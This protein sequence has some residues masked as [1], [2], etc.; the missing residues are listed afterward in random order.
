M[1]ERGLFQGGGRLYAELRARSAVVLTPELVSAGRRRLAI[2]CA[3]ITTWTVGAYLGLLFLAHGP[4]SVTL[5][6]VALGLAV[7]GVAFCIGHDANHDAFLGSR[8]ANR[9]VGL[10]FDFIGVSSYIWRSKHNQA[11]HSFT[12][13]Q[14]ADSDIEQMP[15]ARL[16]PDQPLHW[17]HRFQHIYMW[18]LYGLFT[19]RHHLFGDIKQL[20][21]GRIADLTPVARPRGVELAYFIGGKVV[22]WSWTAVIPLL[23]HPWY[24]VLGAFLIVSWVS[25]FTVATVFQLAH[26]TDDAH[27]SSIDE[28]RAGP[29]KAWADHQVETTVDF[30][31]S[32]AFLRWY[33]GGLNF[34]VEH[35]LFPKV[36]HV[37]YP[38]L[39]PIVRDTCAE[40][41]VQHNTQATLRLALASHVRWLRQMGRPEPSG[42]GVSAQSPSG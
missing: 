32:N 33:L 15:L 39:F 25:G 27:F 34:Q 29:A 9:V 13:V 14:G 24:G 36:S 17:Y 37:H 26:C 4:L 18:L 42:I 23:M 20:I 16:A 19:I 21:T 6:S 41:G 1:G 3:V 11:H 5:W 28:L 7:A 40:L 38:L 2:K 30:A 35:H 8:R 31:P 10:A 12:N 22:F